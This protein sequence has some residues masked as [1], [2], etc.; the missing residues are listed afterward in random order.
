MIDARSGHHDGL[1]IG[2][3]FVDEVATL[4]RSVGHKQ[5]HRRGD[6]LLCLKTL[7]SLVAGFRVAVLDRADRVHAHDD[8]R[9]LT[10]AEVL[11]V[12]VLGAQFLGAQGCLGGDPIVGPDQIRRG[13]GRL[14]EEEQRK[15]VDGVGKLV[16]ARSLDRQLMKT[17]VLSDLE[18]VEATVDILDLVEAVLV[19]AVPQPIDAARV[20]SEDVDDVA[21]G[22]QGAHRLV[23]V[24][25]HATGIALAR[26]SRGRGVEGENGDAHGA[27]LA[28]ELAEDPANFV[29]TTPQDRTRRQDFQTG[30]GNRGNNRLGDLDRMCRVI[31]V[32]EHEH[33][34]GETRQSAQ[35]IVARARV[36]GDLERQAEP[37]RHV[38]VHEV[39][40]LRLC[41]GAGR[42]ELGHLG[43]F[44]ESMRS[45]MDS[46]S[47]AADSSRS[48]SR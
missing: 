48:F 31:V 20:S 43:G 41:P 25:V 22:R 11:G 16:L 35:R 46:T 18:C 47:P 34:P 39:L 44:R 45:V 28:K 19:P 1:R 13:E 9:T 37:V 33:L 10:G 38:C 42:Q 7:R 17:D 21:G 24:D 30:V 32:G 23:D 2:A 5:V 40:G 26:L 14:S 27:S 6:P 3:E 15:F 4:C 29:A 12:Q 8:P 36:D